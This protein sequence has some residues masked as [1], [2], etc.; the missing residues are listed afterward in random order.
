MTTMFAQTASLSGSTTS[1]STPQNKVTHTVTSPSGQSFIVFFS[2]SVTV[3]NT[4]TRAKVD[5]VVDGSQVATFSPVPSNA[6]EDHNVFFFQQVTGKSSNFDCKIDYS[7]TNGANN[8]TITDAAV[9]VWRYDT[10]AGLDLQYAEANSSS[11]GLTASY[12]DGASVTFTPTSTGNYFA[13]G[14]LG[15][16]PGSTT[17]SALARLDVNGTLYPIAS[18]T[19]AYWAREAQSAVSEAYY[20]FNAGTRQSL[21]G[22]ANRTIKV[23]ASNE[24]GTTGSWRYS[25]VLAF[26]ED[27]FTTSNY[28]SADTA[29]EN[30]TTSLTYVS[31]ASVTTDTPGASSDYLV[32]AGMHHGLL[33]VPSEAERSQA[34]IVVD[35]TEVQMSE[36]RYKEPSTPSDRL[37]LGT[38]YMHTDSAAFTVTTEHRLQNDTDDS[39]NAKSSYIIILKAMDISTDPTVIESENVTVTDTPIVRLDIGINVSE[40]ITVTDIPRYYDD[41]IYTM[42][43][44][45]LFVESG[46]GSL[47]VN[48]SDN[49]TVTESVQLSVSV[50]TNVSENITVTDTPN[51]ALVHQV[52]TS[53]TI[54]TTESVTL[55]VSAPQINR[56]DMVTLTENVKVE[57]TLQV[58]ASD[59]ITITENVDVEPQITINVVE[60]ISLSENVKVELNSFINKSDSITVTENV[61]VVRE[62][63][64][65]VSDTIT[66]S[67]NVVVVMPDALQI[68]VS[69]NVTLT[70]FVSVNQGFS[71]HASESITVSESVIVDV[72]DPQV[73]ASDSITVTEFV[74]PELTSDISVA[75]NI[76]VS[77]NRKVELNSDVYGYDT[78]A[79]Q[80]N[81]QVS[82]VIFISV[83]DSVT[84][85]E[86]IDADVIQTIAVDDDITVSESID[87]ELESDIRVS[88]T[89]SITESVNLDIPINITVS[90]SITVAESIALFRESGLEA[91]ESIDVTENVVVRI[92]ESPLTASDT[93]TVSENT[94][95][96]IPAMG[97]IAVSDNVTVSEAFDYIVTPLFLSVSD[98]ITV[99]DDPEIFKELDAFLINVDDSITLTENVVIRP[100]YFPD[101]APKLIFVEGRLAY[102]IVEA[103]IPHY[104]YIT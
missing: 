16:A 23:Q 48:K 3:S 44:V 94:I 70:E 56:S 74:D 86:N 55:A 42:E 64:I 21:T 72:S 95:V 87:L 38:A 50:A 25:R 1:S 67:E 57:G 35:G 97:D 63:D 11:T 101:P 41:T 13:L 45:E 39:S 77:E 69:D 99:T 27:A 4:A 83:S 15:I 59:S 37:A 32:I 103:T 75:D 36:M 6:Q 62:S 76:T 68:T 100:P 98:S 54:T 18:D 26:R 43:R 9:T 65:N 82:L 66:T 93:V 92:P 88:D 78:V 20:S 51:I 5:L 7:S 96:S 8:V 30:S 58:R 104:I 49:I 84:L 24:S 12:V 81:T 60:A 14:A 89:V 61:K 52:R 28:G 2:A 10:I 73:S 29:S 40:N 22:G 17:V 85:T 91:S 46:D 90:D 71:A 34:R 80:E 102:K 31:R 79:V 33:V 47:S 53:D 19:T